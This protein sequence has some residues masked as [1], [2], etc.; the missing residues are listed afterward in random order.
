M[1][2]TASAK[3][4]EREAAHAEKA[5]VDG[6]DMLEED[7]KAL[8]VLFDAFKVAKDKDGNDNEKKTLVEKMSEL[9]KV[10]TLI[11]EKV[12]YPETRKLVPELDPTVLKSYEEHHI[13]DTVSNE[14]ASM[15]PS[16]ANFV[17]KTS[18]LID[19]VTRHMDDEEQGWFPQVRAALTGEK[20]QDIGARMV[21]LI[22]E[23]E[24][25]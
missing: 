1:S 24:E 11:E 8:R 6:I 3:K 25:P 14:L 17:A 4:R 12:F 21:A 15:S 9:L 10:H 19:S 5:E 18:V 7:H 16:D 2:T 20:L 22:A 13:V 23:Q